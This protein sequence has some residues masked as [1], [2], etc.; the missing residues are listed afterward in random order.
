MSDVDDLVGHALRQDAHSNEASMWTIRIFFLF[1]RD[2]NRHRFAF[3][4]LKEVTETLPAI[5]ISVS[6]AR[7]WE[8][9][10]SGR[11]TLRCDHGSDVQARCPAWQ[12]ALRTLEINVMAKKE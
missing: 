1:V 6:T 8:W 10:T 9:A 11:G 2:V 7:G 3:A 4:I 5:K 12:G